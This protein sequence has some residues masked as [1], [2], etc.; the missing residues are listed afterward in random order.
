MEHHFGRY[1]KFRWGWRNKIDSNSRISWKAP[2]IK[3]CMAADDDL[4]LNWIPESPSLVTIRITNKN[5]LLGMRLQSFPLFL[6]D[7]HIG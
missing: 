7:E 5:A 3:Y 1:R 4:L 2:F 6:L